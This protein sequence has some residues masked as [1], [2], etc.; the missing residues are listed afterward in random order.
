M[1]PTGPSTE[2]LQLG[3][4]SASQAWNLSIGGGGSL[5]EELKAGH[6]SVSTS[7]RHEAGASPPQLA[8]GPLTSN[9]ACLRPH[10]ALLSL[11]PL[12]VKAPTRS[13]LCQPL[14]QHDIIPKDLG[15]SQCSSPQILTPSSPLAQDSTPSAL[16]TPKLM[17][18]LLP[19]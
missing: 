11:G 8:G 2:I 7:Q 9:T 18:L 19:W 5:R 1:S 16:T 13:S 4:D 6:I 12:E 17:A 15:G 10:I 3:L 14:L